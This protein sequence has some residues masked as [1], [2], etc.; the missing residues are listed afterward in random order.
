MDYNEEVF[1]R[2]YP[3]VVFFVQHLA[4]YKGL[5]AIYDDI[6]DDRDFWRSTCDAHLKLA[7]VAWCNVFG[8]HKEDMHWTKTPTDNTQASQDF[9]HRVLSETRFTQ[10]QWETYHKEML[11][12][13][14]KY[15]AHLDLRSPFNG[16]VPHFDPALQVVYAYQ[17]WARELIR[18]VLLNQPTL[19]SQYEQWE[20]EACSIVPRPPRP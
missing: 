16:S 15:V 13:R 12:F 18:P 5:W 20:A 8:S 3:V 14:D 2:Q 10:G 19:R 1:S 11:D 4:Y 6:R 9:R 7:T 17:E